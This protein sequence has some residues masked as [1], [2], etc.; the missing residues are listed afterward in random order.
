MDALFDS[1]SGIA[2]CSTELRLMTFNV[3]HASP[4]R[5]RAQAAWIAQHDCADVVVLSEVGH[6]PGREALI[7][8]LDWH[9][10][11]VYAPNVPK[12]AD[13]TTIVATRHSNSEPAVSGVSHLPHRATAVTFPVGGRIVTVIGLYV[14]SRG[15]MEQRNVA[16]RAFQLAVSEA[17]PALGKAHGDPDGALLVVSGD[18]NVVEPGHKPHHHVFGP[19][20]Y[21]FYN[22]FT[23]AGLVD[24]Y[25]TIHPSDAE[26]SW[27]GQEGSG[28]RFDH[29]FLTAAHADKITSCGYVHE[30]RARKLSDHSAMIAS[31][32]VT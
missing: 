6:G 26:H 14:P 10:Y 30:V 2:P 11:T 25:R 24:A 3:Q 23:A 12:P 8:A 4:E 31:I 22:S 1:G 9:S 13:Y 29:T 15:P 16:K 19:W 28:Y 27:F 20:E 21:D 17:L 18:L 5:A 7:S 32:T